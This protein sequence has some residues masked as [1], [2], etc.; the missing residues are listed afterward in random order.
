[1][2]DHVFYQGLS[3]LA[4]RMLGSS[5]AEP[6]TW[7]FSMVLDAHAVLATFRSLFEEKGMEGIGLS[8]ISRYSTILS[9]KGES[10]LQVPA[11]ITTRCV[12]CF[13]MDGNWG[14]ELG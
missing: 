8:V 13:L 3:P 4:T 10:V 6:G 14:L 9:L 7:S 5:L 1:M 2:D 11:S 12:Q